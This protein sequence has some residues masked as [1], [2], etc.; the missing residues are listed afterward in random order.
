MST[1]NSLW[2]NNLV[3]DFA[4][5]L[6]HSAPR[7]SSIKFVVA[8]ISNQPGIFGGRGHVEAWRAT[9]QFKI[10]PMVTRL[11]FDNDIVRGVV[12]DKIRFVVKECR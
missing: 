4:I 2:S 7:N 1:E 6:S 12:M 11:V 9:Q 3:T 8:N 5:L 10:P